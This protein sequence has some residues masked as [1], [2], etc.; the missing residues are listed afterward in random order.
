[1]ADLSQNRTEQF[2][3]LNFDMELWQKLY[4]KHQ[5]DYIRKRLVAIK[6]LHE[7]KS[8]LQICKLIGC[9]YNTLTS[10]L[11]K[12]IEG[13]L[14]SLVAPIK[15][16]NSP[17]RLSPEQKQEIKRI[18]LENTPKQ[19]GFSRNIWTGDIILDL[20]QSKWSISLK[21][22][23]IY[24]IFKELNLSYQKAHRDYANADKE[25]QKAF[26]EQFQK[27][28][29]SLSPKEKI[30]FFDEFAVYDRPSLFY[31]WAEVNT[32][33]E[34]P[35][36]EKRTRHKVNGFLGVDAISGKEHLILNPDSKSEDVA[37]Y[38]ALLCDDISKEGYDKLTIYLDR[39]STHKEKMLKKLKIL[40]AV[41]GLEDKITVELN[42]I[43][44]YSP[45][46]NLAEY[47]IHQIRLQIL[48]HM[49]VDATIESIE[50]E[51]ESYLQN[52]QLQTPQQIQ[53]SIKHICKLGTQS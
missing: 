1:M 39:N 6:H 38:I 41:L 14:N 40:L 30:I 27:K 17:Q 32:R 50:A 5:Q 51:I 33:P 15:H 21:S 7:G 43:P 2:Q 4:Y 25:E 13:G 22:S 9:S 31:A 36:D 44:S 52:K 47:I 16:E 3:A 12:Y 49:P 29:E 42:H 28:L 35:S 48:H 34:I 10:W 23:R 24:E 18:M 11:D 53:K 46:L 45:K 8:R 26:V 37:S 20:I 19:H